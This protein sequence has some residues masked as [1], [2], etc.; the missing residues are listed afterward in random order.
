LWKI[1]VD[2]DYIFRF[3]AHIMVMDMHL[4]VLNMSI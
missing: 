4:K 2:T 3:F 1:F